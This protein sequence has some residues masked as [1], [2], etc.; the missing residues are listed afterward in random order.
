MRNPENWEGALNYDWNL[1]LHADWNN[2]IVRI[3]EVLLFHR[4][5]NGSV[6]HKTFALTKASS[7]SAPYLHGY[8]IFC[9]LQQLPKF[10]SH[11]RYIYDHTKDAKNWKMKFQNKFASLL[12]GHSFINYI[13]L[14]LFCMRNR[15]AIYYP[16]HK[17][18]GLIGL[19]RGFFFPA[20]SAYYT[21]F[22]FI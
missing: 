21:S 4:A 9:R 10:M 7:K 13:R 15:K 22:N 16:A 3:A 1:T 11:C 20:F 5:H 6:T 17:T 2:G 18:E 8:K 19:S 12:L 14:C